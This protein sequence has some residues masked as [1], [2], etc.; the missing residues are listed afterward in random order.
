MAARRNCA[1]V[2]GFWICCARAQ[3]AGRTMD[4]E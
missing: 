4:D 3:R 1:L 2:T